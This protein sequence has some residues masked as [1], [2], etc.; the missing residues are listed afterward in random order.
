MTENNSGRHEA[1]RTWPGVVVAVVAVAG[2]CLSGFNTYQQRQLSQQEDR[3]AAVSERATQVNQVLDG[4]VNAL[5]D[6]K[7]D[8][9]AKRSL[10]I[11]QLPLDLN[12]VVYSMKEREELK[13]ITQELEAVGLVVDQDE[14]VMDDRCSSIAPD[15]IGEK[16]GFPA[17]KTFEWA[18]D[19]VRA[20]A[21]LRRTDP[22]GTGEYLF[23]AMPH[24]TP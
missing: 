3:R 1:W 14:V 24:P 22:N 23:Q 8:W 16:N 15:W 10:D 11:K 13:Q 19:R 17:D 4:C 21:L 5:I 2:L 12:G 9:V 18:T 6:Y 20:I 7:A